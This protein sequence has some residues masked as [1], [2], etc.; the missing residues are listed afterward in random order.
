MKE[1]QPLMSTTYSSNNI[2]NAVAAAAKSLEERKEE[3]NRQIGRAH[4]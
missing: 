4:V 2:L 3:V 1:K